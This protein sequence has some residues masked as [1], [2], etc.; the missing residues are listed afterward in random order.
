MALLAILFYAL[1][2]V[3]VGAFLFLAYLLRGE[4]YSEPAVLEDW[5]EFRDETL[6]ARFAKRKIPV[7]TLLE[8]YFDEKIVFKDADLFEALKKRDQYVSYSFT[9][10]HLRYF[11]KTFLPETIIH[12][13]ADDERMVR[14]HYDRGNDF[15]G[16][17][18]DDVMV[19][20]SG[21]YHD[22]EGSCGLQKG[23]ENKMDLVAQ[24]LRMKPGEK[25]LDIGCG[26]G[27]FITHCAKHY[28][29]DST[30]VTLS[31]NQTEFGNARIKKNGVEDRARF[32]CMDY[33]EIPQAKYNKIS[34]LEMAEHVGVKNFLPFMKQVRSL[35]EDDGLFLLQIAGLRRHW[36]QR[37]LVWG[38][39]MAKYIFPGADASPPLAFSVDNLE[40]AG[41]E[42]HSV[43]NISYHYTITIYQWYKEWL[44]HEQEVC[45][46]YGRR[47]Y[48]IWCWFLVWAVLIG[49]EG[50]SACYQL[51][52][53]KNENFVDRSHWVS[54]PAMRFGHQDLAEGRPLKN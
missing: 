25:H 29:T 15:F 33:R 11:L 1:L 40:K 53:A 16:W 54:E 50:T 14:W 7:E 41:F 37:D 48:L 45:A 2:A 9:F 47:W 10:N 44:T 18:L 3:I 20:T 51:L 4:Y 12:T 30:G 46:K 6:R 13:K 19:Y 36:Q 35:L 26:W 23:Q 38:L 21:I 24:K 22:K 5:I 17:F 31:R 8:A 39:Y 43:D 49:R 42:V 34:C 32:L 28:G 27:T 52:A